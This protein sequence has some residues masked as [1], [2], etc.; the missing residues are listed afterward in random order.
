M[1]DDRYPDLCEKCGDRLYGRVHPALRLCAKHT[2]EH[3]ANLPPFACRPED[4]DSGDD[5]HL[6]C[7]DCGH[8]WD[9]HGPMGCRQLTATFVTSYGDVVEDSGPHVCRCRVPDP[10]LVGATDKDE[11]PHG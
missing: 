4:I 7:P 1:P 5:L 2:H 10:A 3:L 9:K 8:S 11:A 6:N